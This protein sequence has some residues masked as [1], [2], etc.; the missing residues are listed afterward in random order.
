MDQRRGTVGYRLEDG[1]L[2]H[3]A[4][5]GRRL[6]LCVSAGRQTCAYIA[7]GSARRLCNLI[8][9]EICGQTAGAPKVS[10]TYYG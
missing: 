1:R 7:V 2:V 4:T 6:A 5:A 10:G 3:A 8:A 9:A